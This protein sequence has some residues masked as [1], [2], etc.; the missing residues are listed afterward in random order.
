M[1]GILVKL[2]L[3]LKVSLIQIL[4]KS[5]LEYGINKSVASAFKYSDL[6]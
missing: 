5:N 1:T 6:K 4:L 3:V 2:L